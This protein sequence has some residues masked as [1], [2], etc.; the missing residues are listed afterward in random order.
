MNPCFETI[1]P[2]LWGVVSEVVFR[3]MP[4]RH[5][6]AFYHRFGFLVIRRSMFRIGQMQSER[7]SFVAVTTAVSTHI[8]PHLVVVELHNGESWM[9]LHKLVGVAGWC[10][11]HRHG[12]TVVSEV[13]ADAAP[14]DGHGVALCRITRAENQVFGKEGEAIVSKVL[15]HIERFQFGIHG[16]FLFFLLVIVLTWMVAAARHDSQQQGGDN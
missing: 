4:S 16:R 1:V 6:L 8:L 9:V 2:L 10:H 13:V 7:G 11:I 14:S 12:R 5:D 3:L 15:L